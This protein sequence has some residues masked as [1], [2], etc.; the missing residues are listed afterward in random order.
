MSPCFRWLILFPLI[1]ITGCATYTDWTLTSNRDGVPVYLQEFPGSDIPQFRASVTIRASRNDVVSA[2]TDF[3]SYP[4][5]VYQC[6]RAEVIKLAGYTQAYIYQVTRLPLVRDRDMIMHGTLSLQQKQNR[7]T[8]ELNTEPDYCR[9]ETSPLC[10]EINASNLVR[11]KVASG[12][13]SI[14][15]LDDEHVRVDWQQHMEPG[16]WLPDWITRMMLDDV[17]RKSLSNLKQR[18]ENG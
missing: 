4:D 11:V 15:Q 6:E 17:P 5:W 1:T 10:T 8:I 3:T 9:E 18:L 14:T 16:G 7:V 13:F 2:L 12:R